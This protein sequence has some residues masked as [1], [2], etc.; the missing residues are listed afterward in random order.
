MNYKY[1]LAKLLSELTN[2]EVL[3][4]QI[5]IPERKMGDF[6]FPCF[7][8]AKELKKAPPT[9]STEL[10]E[11]INITSLPWLQK[12][13]ATGPYIN[14]FIEKSELARTVITK[15]IK[16]SENFGSSTIGV[17]K[18]IVI[19]YSSPNIA[20]PF[21][22]GHLRSTV[23]GQALYNI[24][25]HL[26]YTCIGVNHLGDWGTQFGKLIA[27]YKLWSSKEEIEKGGIPA[28]NSIYVKF[29][30]E[31]EKDPSLEDQG[32]SY[33]LK[34]EQGDK[35]AL[36]IW[37]FFNDISLKEFERVYNRLGIKFDH[38]T[39]ESFY[40]DKMQNVLDELERKNLL[41]ES[42]G[43]KIVD[44]EIFDLPPCLLLRADGGT[45]YHTRDLAT[46]FYRKNTYNFEKV[47]YV[48]AIDQSLHF[49][50]LFK[51]IERMQY[52]WSADMH[53]VPFGLV[54]LESG[55]LSTRKGNVVLMEDLLNSAVEK[56]KEIIDEKNAN[57]ENKDE[58]AEAVGIGAIVFNDLYNQ[59]IKD[60]TFSLEKM[61]NFDG[62]TGPFV[63]YSHVRANSVLKKG[64]INENSQLDINNIDYTCL[65]DEESQNLL[66]HLYFF[67]DKLIE[68]TEKLEPYIVTRHITQTAQAFNKFYQT[69]KIL[70]SPENVKTARL[71]LVQSTKNMLK[72][73]LKLIGIQA[74]LQM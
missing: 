48:T 4:N 25:K 72:T 35:E 69:H 13:V 32:R 44:L 12:A 8:L 56:A 5:E 43:A 36:D 11:K 60:V 9:I 47:L 27:A 17:G 26:G 3:P 52:P 23:I 45:L 73:G 24:Y 74:P 50:Q 64:G 2:I 67:N 65:S 53:H 70:D 34:M 62:E 18:T 16:D 15:A 20:K 37:N 54:S 66:Y 33:L 28:L 30:E 68:A 39:G 31:A 40:Q 71:A 29:H 10:S 42:Q 38:Y 46:A 14:F 51:V 19:D 63:Q 57:L 6:A 22:V 49:N 58:I 21:H 59:R 55:K 7:R 61:L 1:E 41:Q